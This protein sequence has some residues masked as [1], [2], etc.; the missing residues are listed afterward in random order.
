MN[1]ERWKRVKE[2]FHSAL[3]RGAGEE[4]RAFLD[5]A[6][7]G[8]AVTRAEVE[9]LVA[10]HEREGEFLDAPAVGLVAERLLDGE[11]GLEAGSL[12]SSYRI[13]GTLGEGGMGKVYLA[14]D[15]RLG[16]RVAL[17]LLPAS[18]VEDEERVRR[19]EQE[20]RAASALNHPNIL[21]IHEIG[22]DGHLRF[23]AT[24]YVEGATL[25]EHLKRRTEM[26]LGEVLEIGIQIAAALS[27]AHAAR[28][29]H[30]DIKP[31]N[32][33]LR[34]HGD[35]KVLDFGLAKPTEE[36]ETAR[37]GGGGVTGGDSFSKA[38]VNTRP[39]M[40]LGTT[41]YMSPEQARGFEIDARTDVWSLGVVL[42]EM[43]AGR[44]PFT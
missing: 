36:E 12:V 27:A 38:L 8:D 32:L 43:L 13:V 22:A 30:R 23:I 17:K 31:E 21:T 14:E 6:C 40:V 19:F 7:A 9:S 44:A 10:A 16:R 20:A 29:V 28:I 15:S 35:V 18:F 3:E 39:G 24:E 2:L 34:P 42:Y 4:R 5:E 41:G 37:G 1:Q 25:R 33:M 26:R 11:S